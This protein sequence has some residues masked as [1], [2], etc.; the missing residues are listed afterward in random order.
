MMCNIPKLD[1]VNMNT[2][3]KFGVILSFCSQYIEIMMEGWN[4]RKPKSNTALPL[5]SMRAIKYMLIFK[6]SSGPG[7]KLFVK[8]GRKIT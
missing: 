8:K 1:L 7:L 5:F 4:D 2:Y 6:K 3:I